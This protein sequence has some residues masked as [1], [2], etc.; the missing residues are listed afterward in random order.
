MPPKPLTLSKHSHAVDDACE[1]VLRTPQQT[2]PLNKIINTKRRR[3]SR[4][5]SR[6][7]HMVW[8]SQV[9]TDRFGRV[10]SKKD[11][12]RMSNLLS[13]AIVVA[14]HDLNVLRRQL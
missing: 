11:R 13:D 14:G 6:W 12:T 3:K 1:R 4:R 9:I 10:A 5:S 2:R 7:Q 8:T